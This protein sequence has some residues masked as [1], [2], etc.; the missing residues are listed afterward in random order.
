MGRENQ[1]KSMEGERRDGV[2]EG[3]NEEGWDIGE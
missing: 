2:V 3:E 1:P